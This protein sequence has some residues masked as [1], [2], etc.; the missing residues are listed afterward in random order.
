VSKRRHWVYIAAGSAKELSILKRSKGKH[1]FD[2][3]DVA[4]LRG[5]TGIGNKVLDWVLVGATVAV[6]AMTVGQTH[7]STLDV[8]P[9][10]LADHRGALVVAEISGTATGSTGG[11][12]AD[13]SGDTGAFGG[14]SFEVVLKRRCPEILGNP[15]FYD[16]DILALCLRARGRK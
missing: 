16:D 12:N 2:N 15:A 3:V 10:R 4:S 11:V 6:L 5:K 13:P 8:T 7:A 1:C 14:E 9:R